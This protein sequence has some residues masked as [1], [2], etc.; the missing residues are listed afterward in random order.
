MAAGV[1]ARENGVRRSGPAYDD[2]QVA[3]THR[4]AG[5]SSPSGVGRGK[6][7]EVRGRGALRTR[8]ERSAGEH[9]PGMSDFSQIFARLSA[10]RTSPKGICGGCLALLPGMSGVGLIAMTGTAARELI[11]ATDTVSATLERLQFT[12][13]EGP[14]IEAFTTGAPVLAGDLAAA[15]Y[16]TRWPAFAPD[17]VQAGARAV[18]AYPL[19]V[20]A[21]RIGVMEAYRVDPGHL[22]DEEVTKAKLVCHAAMVVLLDGQFDSVLPASTGIVPYRA[23]VHQAT[24]MVVAQLGVS[25][26]EAFV[27]LRARAYAEGRTVE[28]VARDIV[29]RLVRFDEPMV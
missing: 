11:C 13:G 8:C 22:S 12:L 15:A 24:G 18:F 6:R 2:H 3:R 5:A 14:S 1:P 7:P 16:R 4:D 25:A 21:A 19:R 23:E 17:A 27:R 26:E 9:E 28:D 20:G 29:N 10:S